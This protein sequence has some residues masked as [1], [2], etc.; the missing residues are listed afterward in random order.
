MENVE[1]TNI[2]RLFFAI[3]VVMVAMKPGA[4]DGVE[5]V[6]L[7]VEEV[8][9]EELMPTGSVIFDSPK[10]FNITIVIIISLLVIGFLFKKR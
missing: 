2:F 1:T 7:V 4:K 5:V 10:V 9:P 6:E 3:A 8:V